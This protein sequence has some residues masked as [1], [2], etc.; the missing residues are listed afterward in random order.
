MVAG[1]V[2]APDGSGARGVVVSNGVDVELT[3][4]AGRWE[5]PDAGQPFVWV[6]RGGL[7]DCADWYLPTESADPVFRL[8]DAPARTRFAQITDL[9]LDSGSGGPAGDGSVECKTATLE[10]VF[11]ELAGDL[12]REFVVATGD[13]TNRGVLTDYDEVAAALATSPI[14]VYVIPGN[15][16]H[17]GAFFEPEPI[18][19]PDG[20]HPP[21]SGWWYERNFGPRWF[22]FTEGGM[23]VVVVDWH[24]WDQ[25]VDADL[26]SA[27]LR[28]DL[29]VAS[30][31]SQVLV[32][33]HDLMHKSFFEMIAESAPHVNLVG[34]LSGHWHTVRSSRV[35]GALHLN[36]G[37]AMFGSWDWSPPHTRLL[38]LSGDEIKVETV[39]LGV[40]PDS[41]HLSF[42]TRDRSD[43]SET[44]PAG[45]EWR[46]RLPG[47]NHLGGPTVVSNGGGSTCAVG[48]RDEDRIA[49]GVTA[50]DIESGAVVWTVEL[51]A[52]LLAGTAVA[53]P[54]VV[55]STIDGRI[56]LLAGTSGRELWSANLHDRQGL[57]LSARPTVAAGVVIAG[58]GKSFGG[59]SVADG[60]PVWH[61]DDLGSGEMYPSYG[62]AAA[63]G[64][65]VYAGFPFAEPSLFALD[66]KTGQTIWSGGRNHGGSPAG[67]LVVNGNRIYGLTHEPELFCVDTRNGAGQFRVPIDG[68]YTWASPVIVDG[69]VIVVS[70]D[71]RVSCLDAVDGRIRW[72]V[73]LPA[74]ESMAFAPY[75]GRRVS[76][77]TS[78][79]ADRGRVVTATTDGSIWTIEPSGGEFDRI[80]RLPAPIVSG[81]AL[82]GR[83]IMATT[84]DGSLW[85]VR[86]RSGGRTA[87]TE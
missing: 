51:G 37:N 75:A 81:I 34:S 7:V 5:L 11:R 85:S 42:S 23:H 59:F 67:S 4:E 25:N 78:P 36:T 8:V 53:G 64:D 63:A 48:W 39:A 60:D 40:Q 35:G 26:Q 38:E 31:G 16:D 62:H 22:S 21:P 72:A 83:Q 29:A 20:E 50:V 19:G 15:H 55:G 2:L 68:R 76:S 18:V 1:S 49:G 77:I 74:E 24:S 84:A 44:L 80:A 69:G 56:S 43:A 66:A 57:W 70:G 27:W 87:T 65:V 47:V 9:H 6:H 30:P 46:V 17:Y 33:S 52:P 32:L 54:D 73:H 45:V 71:G 82:A 86:H 3:D 28:A 14:P 58:S 10:A 13:L 12:D 41:R 61:R 79:V